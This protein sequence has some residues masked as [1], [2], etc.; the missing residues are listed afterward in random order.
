MRF[1][2]ACLEREIA[3]RQDHGGEGRIRTARFPALKTLAIVGTLA[4][5]S[6]R[7]GSTRRGGIGTGD[8]RRAVRG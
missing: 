3:A 5:F 1:L 2:A 8:R 7:R 4:G 6:L